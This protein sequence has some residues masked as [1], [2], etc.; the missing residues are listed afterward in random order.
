MGLYALVTF[1]GEN[2]QRLAERWL[3]MEPNG[4]N[5]EALVPIP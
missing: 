5:A 1:Y 2:G 4:G 3:K